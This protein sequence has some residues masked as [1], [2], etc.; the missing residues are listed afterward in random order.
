MGLFVICF[1]PFDFAQGKCAQHKPAHAGIQ[2]MRCNADN[3]FSSFA[4]TALSTNPRM[5]ESS[6]ALQC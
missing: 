3:W 1:D 5:R 6:D 4:S 2:M